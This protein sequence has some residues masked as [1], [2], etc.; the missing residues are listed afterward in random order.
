M[1]MEDFAPETITTSIPLKRNCFLKTIGAKL[2]DVF[3]MGK[4]NMPAML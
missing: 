4:E 3:G 1:H 2:K